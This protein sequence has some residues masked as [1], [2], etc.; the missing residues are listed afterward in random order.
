MRSVKI[1]SRYAKSLL[2]LAKDESLVEEIAADMQAL[3][4]IGNENRDLR[5]LLKSPVVKK[6][7]KISVFNMIFEA[8]FQK[9]TM[10]FIQLITRKNREDILLEIAS[11]FMN[12]YRAM[13]G[14]KEAR[15]I[16]AHALSAEQVKSVEEHL[17][18]WAKGDVNIDYQ[19]NADIL[20][21]III[22]LEDQ[23]Y[24]GSVAAKIAGLKQQFSKNLYVPQL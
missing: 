18:T 19:V 23:E 5:L 14:I 6:D 17:R 7:K 4:N 16:T 21:G 22:R 11:S 1:A 10:M 8:S 15:V 2:I 24:N 20:G 12:Q 3:V 13:K 9:P